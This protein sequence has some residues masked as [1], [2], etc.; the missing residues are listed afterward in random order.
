MLVIVGT[1]GEVCKLIVEVNDD[2]LMLH[3]PAATLVTVNVCELVI[4]LTTT[5]TVPPAPI[6]TG[7]AGTPVTPE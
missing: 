3:V 4:L 5:S 2:G 6:V 1:D 7:L